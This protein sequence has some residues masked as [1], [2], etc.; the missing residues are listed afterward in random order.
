MRCF[1]LA[2]VL[3]CLFAGSK[4]QTG[5]GGCFDTL[6]N[7][8]KSDE[9]LKYFSSALTQTGLDLTLLGSGG[10]LIV[11]APTDEAFTSL[12]DTSVLNM[13]L[14]KLIS[15]TIA[16]TAGYE[17]F[18]D[19]TPGSSSTIQTLCSDCNDLQVET[20]RSGRQVLNQNAYVSSVIE[21][22]N[23]LLATIDSLLV[24]EEQS[25]GG[26]DQIPK[27]AECSLDDPSCCDLPPPEF[28]C[29]DQLLWNKC[30]EPWMLLGNGNGGFC[31]YTCGRCGRRPS[32]DDSYDRRPTE[33]E[34]DRETNTFRPPRSPIDPR[35]ACQCSP[36]GISGNVD[37]EQAGCFNVNVAEYQSRSIGETS[38]RVFG[39]AVSRYWGGDASE[40]SN[41]FSGLWGNLAG[42]W[43]RS[44]MPESTTS[45]CYVIDPSACATARSSERY[46]GAAWRSCD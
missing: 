23:G 19:L 17:T 38:G 10:P 39:E 43:A 15:Y 33:E 21:T 3:S 46:P 6:S 41:Y 7:R 26:N 36:D 24:P 44:N 34:R 11:F 28:T 2:I 31:R 4:A 40:Y 32:F 29:R 9:N 14:S 35:I 27:P 8:I 16:T 25:S 37:T 13:E 5:G 45:I 12:E 30:D 20:L 42:S 1:L 18:L 22:C